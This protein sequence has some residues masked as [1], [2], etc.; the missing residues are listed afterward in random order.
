MIFIIASPFSSVASVRREAVSPEYAVAL[1][2]DNNTY[3]HPAGEIIYKLDIMG[4]RLL[5]T[6]RDGDIIFVCDG[7]NI[8][9]IE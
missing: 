8:E 6:D 3:A 5:R 9:Y 1:C 4:I 2:G 7:E